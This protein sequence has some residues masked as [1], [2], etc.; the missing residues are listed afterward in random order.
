[1]RIA[2]FNVENFFDRAK[3][4]NTQSWAEGRPILAAQAELNALV[5]EPV[6]TEPMKARMVDLLLTLGLTRSDSAEFAVLRQIR[7]HLVSRPRAG[8]VTVVAQGRG[9]WVGWVE[10]TTE[11][12]TEAAVANTARVIADLR[13]D[14]L[15]VVEAENRVVLKHFADAQLMDTD[16]ASLYPQIMLIDGN[17][18][19]GIDVAILTR[20][21]WPLGSIRTHVDDSDGDG[22]IFSRDCPEYEVRTPGGHRLVVLVNHLKSKGFGRQS[23]NDAKRRRQ[24]QRI[25][26]IYRRL[27][28]ESV[29][30]VAV[31]GDF[32]DAADSEPL[33]PLLQ[34]TD[35]RDITMH[36]TFN[37]GGRPGTFGNCTASQKIDYILLS[38]ALFSKV[39]GGGIHRL[40]ACGG[41]NGTLWPHYDTLTKVTDAAS[42]HSA[43]YADLRLT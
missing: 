8:G 12:V 3:A 21:G 1:M 34:D 29:V 36:E 43:I 11:P 41:K 35:L 10:L 38:P 24:A 32:N 25:A 31:L 42:D 16:D 15:G 18:D 6:Y 23:D 19:R 22:I 13:P 20:H 5:E 39:T 26:D 33:A 7:G 4:L 9:D 17:D 2:S 40:G 30:Y 37:D 28:E 27:R 14:I